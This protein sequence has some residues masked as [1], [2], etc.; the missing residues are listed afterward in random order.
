MLIEIFKICYK[1]IKNVDLNII[2]N[3]PVISQNLPVFLKKIWLFIKKARKVYESQKYLRGEFAAS[4][5]NF[6]SS[7]QS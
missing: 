1:F 7:K 4:P 2:C 6:P 3:F 5:E